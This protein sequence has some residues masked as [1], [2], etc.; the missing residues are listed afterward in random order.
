MLNNLESCSAAA[1]HNPQLPNSK[2]DVRTSH[3]RLKSATR[4]RNPNSL[5]LTLMHEP[6]ACGVYPTTSVIPRRGVDHSPSTR[7]LGES[8]ESHGS[9]NEALVDVIGVA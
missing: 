5:H 3:I 9:H 4:Q 1:T 8:W 7:I 6:Q 2:V